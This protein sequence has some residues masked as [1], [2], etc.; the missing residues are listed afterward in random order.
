MGRGA[1]RAEIIEREDPRGVAYYWIG[2][3]KPEDVATPGSDFEA[4]ANQQVSITPLSRDLTCDSAL[5][6]L[7]PSFFALAPRVAS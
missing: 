4:V 2:G 5:R 3:T 1:Y 7:K 6:D